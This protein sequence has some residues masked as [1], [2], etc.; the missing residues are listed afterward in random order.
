MDEFRAKR[1]AKRD[2]KRG[3]VLAVLP[4]EV[5][6]NC[7]GQKVRCTLRGVLKRKKTR[8]KN[9]L[10]VGDFVLFEEGVIEQVCDRF[11]LLSRQEHLTRR[12]QQLIAANID[13]VLITAS[14]KKPSLKPPLIDRYLI[15][16]YKGNMEPV[17]VI[18]KADL[19]VDREELEKIVTLYEELDIPVIVTSIETGEG[20]DQLKEQMRNVTSVFSGQS[21]VGKSSLINAMLGLDLAVGEVVSK[22]E[23]GAHTTSNAKLIELDCGGFCIDTPGIRSFGVWDIQ[24]EDLV[25]HFPEIAEVGLDC[26]FP[27]CTHTHEPNCAVRAAVEE[28]EIPLIRFESYLR[29]LT[30]TSS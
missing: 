28:G 30:E 9:L 11:S 16:T 25:N 29:L 27:N 24:R 5:V 12:K 22:T 4:E 6:V 8:D 7:E 18:N 26:H 17:I 13:Q 20:L 2:L 14:V 15:A 3:R 10:V 23:K 21:G 19:A 1:L